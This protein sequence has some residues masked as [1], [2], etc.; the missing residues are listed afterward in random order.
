[1][2]SKKLYCFGRNKTHSLRLRLLQKNMQYYILSDQTEV[3]MK[4]ILDPL[5]Y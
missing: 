1:M 4:N 2:A 5:M 3:G